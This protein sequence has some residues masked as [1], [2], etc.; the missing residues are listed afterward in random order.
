MSS[1]KP[2][3]SSEIISGARVAQSVIASPYIAGDE[4]IAHEYEFDIQSIKD[5]NSAYMKNCSW[6]FLCLPGAGCTF[7]PCY[8]GYVHACGVK[9]MINAVDAR[10]LVLTADGI[11]YTVDKHPAGCRFAFQ[12]KGRISKTV[13]YDMITDC[14]IEEPAGSSGPLCCLVP[15][16]LTKVHVDTASSGVIQTDKGT[17]IKHEL[18]LEGL[19]DPHGFKSR[20]WEMRRSTISRNSAAPKAVTM[21]RD[22]GAAKTE[23][24]SVVVL[25]EQNNLLRQQVKLLEKIA[26][27]TG[28]N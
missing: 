28:T 6:A 5:F 25:K 14:D 13:P 20:V 10:K 8:I 3:L 16:V 4:S 7:A 11:R 26:G 18:S 15:N 19:V 23:S 9:N 21:A 27:N 24:A 17:V 12:E 1:T 2:L 22:T